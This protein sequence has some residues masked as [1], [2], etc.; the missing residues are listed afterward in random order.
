M[1]TRLSKLS[2]NR[3]FFKAILHALPE[4]QVNDQ[5][6]LAIVELASMM[7]LAYVKWTSQN[8]VEMACVER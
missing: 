4:W 2:L 7:D 3:V 8:G 6:M 1:P 5:R